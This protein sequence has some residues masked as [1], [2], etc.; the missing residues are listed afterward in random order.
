MHDSIIGERLG[1]P[2][3]SVMTTQFVSAA[4]LMSRVLGAEDYP[5]VVVEHPI[6]SASNDV[7]GDRARQAAADSAAI[8]LGS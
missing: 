2:S 6:S 3:V 1:L 7:L 5:F 8:L 4:Q